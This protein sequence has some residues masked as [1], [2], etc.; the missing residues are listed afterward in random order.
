MAGR[1]E[2]PLLESFAE[3]SG[4]GERSLQ[5]VLDSSAELARSLMQSGA[6]EAFGSVAPSG[7][8]GAA[9]S[10]AAGIYGGS[11]SSPGANTQGLPLSPDESGGAAVTAESVASTFFESGFGMAAVVKGLMG[12]FG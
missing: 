10:A 4:G 12:L 1:T 9:A 2:D 3:A 8:M 11:A 7:S 6:P 5:D